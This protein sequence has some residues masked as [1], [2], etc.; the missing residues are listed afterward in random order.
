MVNRDLLVNFADIKEFLR[1][2]IHT[3]CT[4][5]TATRGECID[6]SK[7]AENF[8]DARIKASAEM[9]EYMRSKGLM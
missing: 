4:E 6:G 3:G 1:L 5:C 9:F 8:H 7:V 2:L